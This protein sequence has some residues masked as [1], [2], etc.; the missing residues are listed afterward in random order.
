MSKIT[1][2]RRCLFC[3]NDC[4]LLWL[5]FVFSD[6]KGKGEC[7]TVFTTTKWYN[8]GSQNNEEKPM[9]AVQH[10]GEMILYH[11]SKKT[12]WVTGGFLSLFSVWEKEVA[13]EKFR[14]NS[15]KGDS[16]CIYAPQPDGNEKLV[17]V[18]AKKGIEYLMSIDGLLEETLLPNEGLD[19][20]IRQLAKSCFHCVQWTKWKGYSKYPVAVQMLVE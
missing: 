8:R 3:T 16:F 17:R 13:K 10:E 15:R 14:E 2:Y 20:F 5:K 18:Y 4:L 19:S 6:K 9:K 12:Y 11:R 7:T 1:H